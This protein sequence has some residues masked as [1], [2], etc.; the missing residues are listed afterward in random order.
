MLQV[1]HLLQ[2]LLLLQPHP[3]QNRV[4]QAKPHLPLRDRV[5]LFLHF[6]VEQLQ[7]SLQQVQQK[8]QKERK[9]QVLFQPVLNQSQLLLQLLLLVEEVQ[10][11]EP[12]GALS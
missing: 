1:L 9:V 6:Q 7:Q 12:R 11:E 10:L 5:I 2:A 8:E 4:L 3:L